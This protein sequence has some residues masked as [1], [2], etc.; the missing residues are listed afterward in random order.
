VV[1]IHNRNFWDSS[2]NYADGGGIR[3][4]ASAL[5]IEALMI[6]I[7]KIEREHPEKHLTS[8]EPHEKPKIDRI[9]ATGYDG[10]D[11]GSYASAYLPCHYFGSSQMLSFSLT[12][13]RSDI[14]YMMGTSTGGF[15]TLGK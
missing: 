7:G 1:S 14:D 13:L 2:L 3:G 8:F 4:Y 12:A 11:D 9:G 6:E 5:M 10:H 15:V